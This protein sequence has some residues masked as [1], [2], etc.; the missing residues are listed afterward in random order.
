MTTRVIQV[1][2]E[3]EENPGVRFLGRERTPFCRYGNLCYCHFFVLWSF[4]LG[5][6]FYKINFLL[7]E[8]MKQRENQKSH[9]SFLRKKEKSTVEFV[10]PNDFKER[11]EK[12]E[13]IEDVLDN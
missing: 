5:I 9:P 1:I 7:E 10:K 2:I 8:L 4:W 3:N 11:F 13:K 12:A 6:Y